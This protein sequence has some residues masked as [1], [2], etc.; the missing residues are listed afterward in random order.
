MLTRE[1]EKGHCFTSLTRDCFRDYSLLKSSFQLFYVWKASPASRSG[2]ILQVQGTV[3]WWSQSDRCH[4]LEMSGELELFSGCS[5]WSC[6]PLPRGG[7]QHSQ[8]DVLHMAQAV[9]GAHSYPSV[10][11]RRGQPLGHSRL[12]AA[13]WAGPQLSCLSLQLCT[14]PVN[15]A[16]SDKPPTP[17]SRCFSFSL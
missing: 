13:G 11:D 3:F 17:L 1:I 5:S 12:V 2:P 6:Q 4:P 10:R 8:T 14:A 16:S 9:A 15:R 7:G